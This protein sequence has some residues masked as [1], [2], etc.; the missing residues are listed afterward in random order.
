[1]FEF[2]VAFVNV[3]HNQIP[4]GTWGLSTRPRCIGTV[5]ARTECKSNQILKKTVA[6]SQV[7]ICTV[8]HSVTADL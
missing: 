2:I 3:L 7:K 6:S 4:R 8:M 5:W 1:M